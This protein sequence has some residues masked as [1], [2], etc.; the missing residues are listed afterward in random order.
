M[1]KQER[2]RGNER[3]GPA[4]GLVCPTDGG[5]QRTRNQVEPKNPVFIPQPSSPRS[6][7]LAGRPRGILP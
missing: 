6:I 2:E 7:T 4:A 1:E 5:G 3:E